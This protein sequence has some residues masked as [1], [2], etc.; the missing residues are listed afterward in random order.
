MVG[1]DT[2]PPAV[3]FTGAT[4]DVGSK[5]GALVNGASTDDTALLLS[6]TNE[7]GATVK[8]YNG[9]S[10]LG[11]ATVSGTTWSYTATVVDG[12][13]YQFNASATDAAGNTSA[14][15]SNFAVI[16]D[17]TPPAVTFTAAT[18]DVGSVTGPL[19]S[20][21][22]TDD[23]A[24]LLSGT[25]EA[26][27]TVNVYNGAVLL[28]NATVSGTTWSYTATVADG[29][30]YQF[31]ASATDAAGNTSVATSNFTVI[32]DTPQS[33]LSASLLDNVTN[34]E[35]SSNI[36][37]NFSANV[38]AATG[39]FIHI[40]NDGGTGFH[41]ESTVNTLNIL[42]TDTTQV[43]IVNG[44][45]T[46]NPTG[47]L[48]LANNYHITIDAGT[49]TASAGGAA[50][51]AYD[52]TSTLNFSTVT[53]GTSALANAAASQVM[54]ANGT[55]GSGHLWLDIEGIGSPSAPSGTALDLAANNYALVAK[56]YNAAGGSSGSDG[57]TTGDFYVAAKNFG[58]GDLL[59]I[60]NQGGAAN[61]LTQTSIVN[62]GNPP[63]TMQ[64]AGTGLGGM[65]DISLAGTLSTFDT[66]SEIKTLL[67]SSTSPVISA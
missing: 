8:V 5:T 14:V 26:G 39:K 1:G 41:G 42:A 48:D 63:T 57:V 45:V 46:I 62:Y 36:V 60:D 50:M 59:Y 52:G 17:T 49:F 20:G 33:T 53:P 56:D 7:A 47:D 16:G 43:T 58:A 6:G 32:G 51:A 9:A 22:H 64:F 44:K 10:L 35:V 2:T 12:T 61:D 18:D 38:T 11:N 13:T 15:T 25:N 4:D 30:T 54:N 3:S 27:A 34:L 37:L 23:T 40:I 31:N 66:L 65:V 24:L 21:A 28:G 29:A 55:L 67:G 19:A